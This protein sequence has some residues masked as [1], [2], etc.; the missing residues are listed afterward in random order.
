MLRM[1]IAKQGTHL[2]FREQMAYLQNMP[3]DMVRP[4]HILHNSSHE[5]FVKMMMYGKR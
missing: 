1:E 5:K 4:V 3:M 2:A